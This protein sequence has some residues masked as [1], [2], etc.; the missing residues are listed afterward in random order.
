MVY[1]NGRNAD[2]ASIGASGFD[3][4]GGRI[5]VGI[6]GSKGSAAALRWALQE[7]QLRGAKVHAV[8]AWHQPVAV[9]DP[10]GMT[11]S[12]GADPST[13]TK[14]VLAAAVDAEVERLRAK[15]DEGCDI[16]I[17][18]ETLEGNP[19]E[20]LVR[21]AEGASLLIVGTRGHGGFVGAM[22]G[23]VSH[24]V[25]THAPCPVVVVTNPSR[26]RRAR[27][28]AWTAQDRARIPPGN[29]YL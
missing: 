9:S 6:D 17:T 22:L 20:T 3:S 1:S 19:A 11:F 12:L 24:H 4:A 15:S 28:E 21:A 5:V 18:C 29:R 26:T 14:I 10:S 2:P 25:V 23:S 8:M 7:A 16:P 27:A 13:A